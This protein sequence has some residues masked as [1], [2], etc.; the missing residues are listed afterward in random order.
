SRGRGKAKALSFLAGGA[1]FRS[2]RYH[3]QAEF[4]TEKAQRMVF[5][6]ALKKLGIRHRRA[7]NTRHSYATMLL[8]AGVNPAFVA[9]QLGHSVT[10]TLTVYS[11]WIEG[12]AS[13]AELD[14]LDLSGPI[15]KTLVTDRS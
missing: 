3:Q 12:E 7:Y 9:S 2:A 8:M 11:K 4:K 15:G 14:K 10:M 13:R 6:R 1:V 5:T